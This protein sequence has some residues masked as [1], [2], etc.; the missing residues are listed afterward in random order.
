MKE[1]WKSVNIWQSY[2]QE[3]FNS[4]QQL[5]YVQLPCPLLTVYHSYQS[6]QH[7]KAVRMDGLNISHIE[8]RI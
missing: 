5:A 1:F 3:A 7:Y 2:E 6:I 8:A 4:V